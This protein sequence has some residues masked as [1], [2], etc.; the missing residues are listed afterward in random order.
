MDSHLGMFPYEPRPVQLELMGLFA[1]AVGSG[2]SALAEAGSGTGKTVCALVPALFGAARHGKRLLYLTRTNSQQ[3]QVFRELRAISG[4]SRVLGTGIQGRHSTCLLLATEREWR[5]AS[6]EELSVLC[7]DRKETSRRREPGGCPFFEELRA[8]GTGELQSW[9]ER[10]LPTVEEMA[11]H[12]REAG[13]CPYEAAKLLARSA[14]VVVAPYVYFLSPFIRAR[15]LDWMNC[16]LEDLVVV[17]DEA[18]NL[19]EFARSLKSLSLGLQTLRL[20]S[21]EA[22]ELGGLYVQDEVRV[23]DLCARMEQI[24]LQLR[25]EYLIDEDGMVPPGAVEEELMYSFRWTSNRLESAVANLAAHGEAIRENRRKGGR[26]PR[27]HLHS[28]G[29]FLALWMGLE[30]DAYVKLVKDGESPRLEAYCMDPGLASEPLGRCHSGLH[31]SGTLSPLEEYRDSLGLGDR[32][33]LRAFPGI[34]PPENRLVLCDPSVSMKY[35]DRL[36]DE[37]M[38]SGILGKAGEICR[39]T[40]RNT[41]VFFPSFD[42]LE[43]S[44]A[45]GLGRSAGRRIFVEERGASQQDLLE[46]VD[47][48]KEEGRR[49]EEGAVLLSVIGGRVSEG[50]DFPDR[51]LDVAV[52]VGIPYPKPTA[53][54]KALQ[55]YYDIRFGK[56]WDYAVRAPT[57]RRL[58]QTIGRLIRSERD[59]GVAVILDRRAVQFRE[60]LPDLRESSDP[61]RDVADFWSPGCRPPPSP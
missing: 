47:S 41:A 31:M 18:H 23:S 50:I 39:A 37:E 20:A 27:S 14:A 43:R 42:L 33:L 38:F 22:T 59:R 45:M 61:A 6:P 1:G 46:T 21:Q 32:T 44:L 11:R 51:E 13:L 57:A 8:A 16:P 29:S 2:T 19:P 12:C 60:Y 48:F 5:T 4:R 35:E 10:T 7:N 26:V 58:L 40:S 15:L 24:V 49:G 3:V 53:R 9:C 36:T 30:S 28:V 56:G 17:V 52:I 34:F 54:Q 55:Y 25:D